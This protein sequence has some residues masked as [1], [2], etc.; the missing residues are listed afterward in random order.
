M[1]FTLPNN[2]ENKFDQ[3]LFEKRVDLSWQYAFFYELYFS[4][5]VANKGSVSG[6]HHHYSGESMD[7]SSTWPGIAQ[8]AT[9]YFEA[10]REGS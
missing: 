7:D 5:A 10:P 2:V 8:E 4:N 9:R 3:S 1:L 6:L